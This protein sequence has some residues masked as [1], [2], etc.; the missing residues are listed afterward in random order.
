MET[1][2]L[3]S[4]Q[5]IA[6]RLGLSPLTITQY[7]WGTNKTTETGPGS[8][9]VGFPP[10]DLNLEG[11]PIWEWVQVAQWARETGR[12]HFNVNHRSLVAAP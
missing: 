11:N 1:N 2:D 3:V 4:I 8:H 9:N 12:G 5:E 6:R 10:E 7:R